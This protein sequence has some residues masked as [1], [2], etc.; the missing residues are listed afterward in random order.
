V[1]LAFFEGSLL[2]S[3]LASSLATGAPGSETLGIK[4]STTL[5]SDGRGTTETL[6][7]VPNTGLFPLETFSFYTGPRVSSVQTFE[8]LSGRKL[9][10]T[11]QP[12]E[13]NLHWTIQ[14]AQPVLPGQRL[15]LKA[16]REK[17]YLEMKE[18][19]VWTYQDTETWGPAIQY[20]HEISLPKNAQVIAAEP[21][22]VSQSV[23]NGRPV[24]TFEGARNNSRPFDVTIK[25]RLPATPPLST[26]PTEGS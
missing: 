20:R 2:N 11:T 6:Y 25:Y 23:Q 19:N 26:R 12:A 9:R 5:E 21:T 13:P 1:V 4:Q 17:P 14:L 24:F 18:K 7:S 3:P 8:D 22:P 16:R 15:F 10:A